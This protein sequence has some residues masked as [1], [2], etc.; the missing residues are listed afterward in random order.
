MTTITIT[1]TTDRHT[2]EP[3][4]DAARAYSLT[5]SNFFFDDF[6]DLTLTIDFP[7]TFTAD[8]FENMI[9]DHDLGE[10]GD[11]APDFPS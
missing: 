11:V 8:D 9:R 2:L 6:D 4:F 10:L 5:L 7:S 1:T 3:L